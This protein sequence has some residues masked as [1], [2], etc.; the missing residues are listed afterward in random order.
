MAAVCNNLILNGT[1]KKT[2][3]QWTT[4]QQRTESSSLCAKGNSLNR[5]E[6]KDKSPSP[7]SAHGERGKKEVC[8]SANIPFRL[9]NFSARIFFPVCA[10]LR[11]VEWGEK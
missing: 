8:F 11:R 6:T 4:S 5:D 2:Q 9:H 7:L 1:R 10:P 3:S